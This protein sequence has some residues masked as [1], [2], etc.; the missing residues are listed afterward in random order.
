MGKLPKSFYEGDTLEVAKGLLGK[1]LVHRNEGVE[2][3]G[4]IVEVEAYIGAIDK[5]AH[6]YNN[7]RT[8]RTEVM[9]WSGG[10][11]YVYLIYGMYY[12]MN[13]VTGR[14][15][16]GAA[17]LLRGLEPVQGIEQMSINR[18][19]KPLETLKRSQII[20]LTN[21]PGKLC[22]AMGI[23]KNNYGEP[24]TGDRIFIE[25]INL[26][27][28]FDI[29]VSKRINIDYAEEARDFEWRFFIKGNPYVS[30]G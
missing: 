12:C 20:N 7:R 26:K 2:L 8:E 23:T 5:A 19:G 18:Y 3:K 14:E 24:L 30:K 16:E 11:V 17:V 1:V 6:S 10:Y 28:E 4:K 27:E 9:F 21:G 13:V 22:R 25:N 29:G 15:G